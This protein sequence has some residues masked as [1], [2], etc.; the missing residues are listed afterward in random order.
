MSR[1]APIADSATAR[2]SATTSAT[3]LSFFRR[4]SRFLEARRVLIEAGIVMVVPSGQ[5]CQNARRHR[6]LAVG[7]AD[8]G[9]GPDQ[10]DVPRRDV[11]QRL[12]RGLERLRKLIPL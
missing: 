1:L 6:L 12:G 8:A 3:P 11:Q 10:K 5:K 2:S 7:D 4:R 9:H